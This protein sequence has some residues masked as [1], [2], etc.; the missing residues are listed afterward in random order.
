MDNIKFTFPDKIPPEKSQLF[1]T[2]ELKDPYTSNHSNR[3]S[4]YSVLI[5]EHLNLSEDNLNKLKVGGLFHDIGKVDVPDNILFKE[6][7]LTDEEFSTIKGHTSRGADI[8]A[9]S[10]YNDIIPIVKYHHEKY[11]GSGYPEHLSGNNIPYFARITA[12]AD[13]FDAMTSKRTYNNVMPVNQVISE[14]KRCKG[15]HFDPELTDVMVDILENH[16]DEI[17]AIKDKYK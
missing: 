13:S 1:K 10:D 7:K 11:D 8:L 14:L 12:I 6:T 2:I 3:V 15:T 5:G 17:Q 9:S 4:E 16:Y